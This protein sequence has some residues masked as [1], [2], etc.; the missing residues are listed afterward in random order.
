MEMG[1]SYHLFGDEGAPLPLII[2]S[3]HAYRTNY[4]T[5]AKKEN[6]KIVYFKAH[7]HLDSLSGYVHE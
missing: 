1:F 6:T 4:I 3:Y 2:E 7:R 5:N